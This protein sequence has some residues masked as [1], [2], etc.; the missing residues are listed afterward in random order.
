M[1]FIIR[2]FFYFY[3]F[4]FFF[5]RILQVF[6]VFFFFVVVVVSRYISLLQLKS[7]R[8]SLDTKNTLQIKNGNIPYIEA[9]L[10]Q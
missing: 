3:L 6:N 10:K 9:L 4:L 2:Y 5:F 8:L 1:T 7:K